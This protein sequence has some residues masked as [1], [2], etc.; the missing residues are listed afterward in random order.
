MIDKIKSSINEI[1]SFDSN[2]LEEI[3]SFRIKFLG[4]KG[5][6][7]KYFVEFKNIDNKQKKEG[8]LILNKLKNVAQ[9][10][11]DDLILKSIYPIFVLIYHP[12]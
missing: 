6:R 10:K 8:G 5:I 12:F 4:K 3:E 11:V 2:S 7:N 9:Q 1:S